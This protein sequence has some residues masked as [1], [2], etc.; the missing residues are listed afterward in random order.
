MARSS[1]HRRWA[2]KA[3]LSLKIPS[4]KEGVWALRSIPEVKPSC[5]PLTLSFVMSPWCTE[6]TAWRSQNYMLAWTAYIFRRERQTSTWFKLLLLGYSLT[7]GWISPLSFHDRNREKRMAG[8]KNMSAHW[9]ST[10]ALNQLLRWIITA[11][12]I[13]AILFPILGRKWLTFRKV[14]YVSWVHKIRMRP[15]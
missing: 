13:I 3:A 5:H 10:I 4:M 14:K 8:E 1:W 6:V 9:A 7:S 15:S 2:I 12:D 11:N